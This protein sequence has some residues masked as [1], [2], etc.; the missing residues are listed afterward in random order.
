[1]IDLLRP[2]VT[3]VDV[4]VVPL[5]DLLAPAQPGQ[6]ILKLLSQLLVAVRVGVETG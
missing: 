2:L 3:D 5:G 4:A 1:V 6:V